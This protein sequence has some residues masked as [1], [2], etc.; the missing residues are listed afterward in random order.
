[1][2]TLVLVNKIRSLKF[3][4]ST[5]DHRQWA[6]AGEVSM[7]E[8]SKYITSFA[9]KFGEVVQLSSKWKQAGVDTNSEQ[10]REEQSNDD[11]S[12]IQQSNSNEEMQSSQQ[13]SNKDLESEQLE[14]DSSIKYT[15][16]EETAAL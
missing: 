8:L 9:A 7:D 3:C 11:P 4:V 12:S 5:F 13:P 2:I 15:N 14:L 16:L 10:P 6:L 1:M